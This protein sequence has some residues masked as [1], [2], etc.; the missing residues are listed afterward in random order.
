MYKRISQI[1]YLTRSSLL[2][3]FQNNHHFLM[4]YTVLLYKRFY[5]LCSWQLLFRRKK[6]IRSSS[7]ILSSISTWQ[8]ML[9]HALFSAIITYDWNIT[10]GRHHWF[11]HE[12]IHG[13]QHDMTASCWPLF[14]WG[15]CECN[16]SCR[17]T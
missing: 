10:S 3:E 7:F 15:K 11:V 5:I 12:A 17:H 8:K 9:M 2:T 6:G 14:T 16:F 13:A 4:A 1:H